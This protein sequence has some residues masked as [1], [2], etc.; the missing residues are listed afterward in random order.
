[1]VSHSSSLSRQVSL[2][3]HTQAAIL[4]TALVHSHNVPENATDYSGPCILRP[5]I[6]PEKDGLKLKVV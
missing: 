6:Q 3:M 4:L 5:D 1:M 2:C